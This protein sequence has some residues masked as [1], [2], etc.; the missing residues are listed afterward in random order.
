MKWMCLLPFCLVAAIAAGQTSPG[1]SAPDMAQEPHHRLLLENSLVRV[2]GVTLRAS[3]SAFT[4]HDHN[5]LLVTLKDCQLVMWREGESPIIGFPLK[6]GGLIFENGGW[7]R[8]I[9]NDQKGKCSFLAVEFLDPNVAD[10]SYYG[11]AMSPPPP[12]DPSGK[13]IQTVPYGTAYLTVAQLPHGDS[14]PARP[15]DVGELLIPTT[16]LDLKTDDDNHIRKSAG[17]VEWIESGHASALENAGE[18]VARFALVRFQPP[19]K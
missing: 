13:D 2:F 15:D 10:V 6:Q 9:R 12:S 5:Y 17:E 18:A 4:R 14:I 16:D 7:A 1:Q 11:V 19:G 8:G 3:E